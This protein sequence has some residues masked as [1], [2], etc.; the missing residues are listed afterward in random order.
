MYNL[1]IG[2]A[3]D[4]ACK[5]ALTGNKRRTR[6]K[7]SGLYLLLAILYFLVAVSSLAAVVLFLSYFSNQGVSGKTP[8]VHARNIS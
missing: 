4:C 7:F 2:I 5:S 6:L 8:S 1:S 3:D